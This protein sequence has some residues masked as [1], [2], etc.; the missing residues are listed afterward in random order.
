M[1]LKFGI[2][3]KAQAVL[4][5]FSINFREKCCCTNRAHLF[6]MLALNR[7]PH[8][9]LGFGKKGD[10]T[11]FWPILLLVTK[12]RLSFTEF[13]TNFVPVN[14]KRE[15]KYHELCFTNYKNLFISLA[16]VKMI[17]I[18]IGEIF[19][20]NN[21]QFCTIETQIFHPAVANFRPRLPFPHSPLPFPFATLV[22]RFLK[23]S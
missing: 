3:L 22:S 15:G 18:Y 4:I 5:I 11:L 13:Y 16:K 12:Q 7:A 14:T 1:Q 20:L 21:M 17:N 6:S 2:A 23:L 10:T 8:V 19:L 9:Y